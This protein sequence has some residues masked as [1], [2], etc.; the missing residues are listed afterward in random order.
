MLQMVLNKDN[1]SLGDR[2]C[3]IHEEIRRTNPSLCRI[4]VTVYDQKTDIL[5]TFAHST[6]GESPI[7][8]YEVPL[9][10]VPSLQEIAEGTKPRIIEDISALSTHNQHSSKLLAS[11]YQSSLTMPIRFNGTLYGFLFLNSHEKGYFSDGRLSALKAYAGVVSLLVINELQALK[12]FKG[13]VQTARE[14]SR[15]RDEETGDHLERMSRYSR[16]IARDIARKYKKSD[17]WVEYIFQFAPLHDVGKVAVPDEVLLKPGKLNTEEFET[18]KSHVTKGGDIIDVMSDEFDLN[19]LTFFQIL[20]NI[21]VYH[22][23]AMDGSGYP[24]GLTAEF[25]PLEARIVAVADVFDA[26]T[27]ARP[28]KKR[29]TN[30]KAISYLEEYAGIKFDIDCVNSLCSHLPKIE[31]IQSEFCEDLFG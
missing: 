26:L 6:D 3:E 16:L 20:Q 27:S 21:V 22:H 7:S 19:N 11:G 5:K 24:H 12:T 29:W 30:D 9:S 18:M 1:L 10:K 13:A 14:F 28:Y 25:I 23:E 4:A 8:F 31:K 15:Q 2:L 17:D